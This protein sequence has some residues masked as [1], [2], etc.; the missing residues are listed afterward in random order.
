MNIYII[1][2]HA[3]K[4]FVI[5]NIFESILVNSKFKLAT[6]MIKKHDTNIYYLGENINYI[7]KSSVTLYNYGL[8]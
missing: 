6:K 7:F 5:A 3:L 1:L 4:G 2:L 8:T